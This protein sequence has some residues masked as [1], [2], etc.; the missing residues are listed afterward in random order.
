MKKA[1]EKGKAQS[2]SVDVVLRDSHLDTT[3]KSRFSVGGGHFRQRQLGF[4]VFTK[5]IAVFSFRVRS[6]LVREAVTLTTAEV[7]R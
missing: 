6:G 2:G 1:V 3:T 7:P 5:F 4:C